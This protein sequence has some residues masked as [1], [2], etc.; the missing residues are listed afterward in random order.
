MIRHFRESCPGAGFR[1]NILE[2]FEGNGYID[3]DIKK[4]PC[5]I[6]RQRRL[7][8]EDFWMKELRTIFPYG[9]N[10]KAK[11][12]DHNIPVGKL[13]PSITRN[14]TRT[15]RCRNNRNNHAENLSHVEFFQTFGNLSTFNLTN[16]YY[17]IRTYLNRLKKKTQ[18]NCLT[19]YI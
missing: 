15:L 16:T 18:K 10:E 12:H 4:K 17:E 13:Y 9:L 11:N 8:R 14:N 2:I 3:N 7:D 6:A 1:I 19:N 5:P